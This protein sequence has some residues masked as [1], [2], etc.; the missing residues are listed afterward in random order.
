MNEVVFE[1]FKLSTM[2]FCCSQIMV[3]LA[4]EEEDKENTDLVRAMGGFCKGIAGKQKTCGVLTGGMGILGLYGGKGSE[5]DFQKRNY[6]VMMEEFITWFE[7]EFKSTDC[8]DLIG[9]YNFTDENNE[10]YPVKCGDILVKSYEKIREI[11]F[12][13]N[14]TLGIREE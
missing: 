7:E 9:V 8:I 13:N 12:K 11:L 6:G 4:L 5:M 1:A 2:G 14:Y 3:K 10:S